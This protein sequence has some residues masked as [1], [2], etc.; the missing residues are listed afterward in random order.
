MGR[1]AG[2]G[3]GE[4][5]LLESGYGKKSVVDEFLSPSFPLL[6]KEFCLRTAFSYLHTKLPAKDLTAVSGPEQSVDW[7]EAKKKLRKRYA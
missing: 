1:A 3:A 4:M 6:F 2:V 7:Q 5:K